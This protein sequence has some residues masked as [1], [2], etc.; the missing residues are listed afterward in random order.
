[1]MTEAEC[2]SSKH[3]PATMEEYMSATS[4]SLVGA[5]IQSAAYL[6]GPRLPEEGRRRRGVRPAVEAHTILVS[7]LLNDVM[8]YER[9]AGGGGREA[10][11]RHVACSCPRRRRRRRPWRR[12]R[13]RSG[14]PY[15]RESR[16]ELQR[17]VFGDG[18]GVVPWSCRE[19]FCQTSKV[20]SAFYRDGDGYSQELS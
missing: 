6:L 7:R 8:T 20:A 15:I 17:L 11:Q 5:I 9:E 3:I 4:H 18:A 14:G 10:Q 12:P 2:A 13:W 16:W 1:M 19:M